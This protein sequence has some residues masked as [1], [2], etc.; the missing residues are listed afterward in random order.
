MMCIGMFF[1]FDI[2]PD[3]AI[4]KINAHTYPTFIFFGGGA[5]KILFKSSKRKKSY[6]ICSIE[7]RMLRLDDTANNC[8]LG[9]QC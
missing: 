3:K 8:H 9:K 7:P 6:I 1:N 2:F 5:F 4:K